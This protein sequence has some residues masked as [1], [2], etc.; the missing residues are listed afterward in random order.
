MLIIEEKSIFLTVSD[1]NAKPLNVRDNVSREVEG[2]VNFEDIIIS[3]KP[4]TILR[5]CTDI[6]YTK[7][8]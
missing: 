4:L 1:T 6:K 3:D 8:A 7:R 5:L 2:G